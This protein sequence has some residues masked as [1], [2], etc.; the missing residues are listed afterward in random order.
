MAIK[1]YKPTTPGQRFKEISAY[2][3]LTPGA[4]PEKSSAQAHQEKWRS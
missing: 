4:K 2:D 1:K 3:D